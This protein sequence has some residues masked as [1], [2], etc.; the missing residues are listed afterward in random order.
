MPSGWETNQLTICKAWRSWIWDQRTH[1]RL[2]AEERTWTGNQRITNPALSPQWH[3]TTTEARY[4]ATFLLNYKY[5]LVND[6]IVHGKS[7]SLNDICACSKKLAMNLAN[8]NEQLLMNQFKVI[9]SSQ[10]Q[11]NISSWT[12]SVP[13]SSQFPGAPLWKKCQLQGLR[14]TDTFRGQKISEHKFALNVGY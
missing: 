1:I 6:F 8:W 4:R 11:C 5:L 13:R 9:T 14:G 10:S 12:L 3:T 7:K 2:V